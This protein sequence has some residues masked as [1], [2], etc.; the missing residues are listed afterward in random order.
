MI[1]ALHLIWIIPLSLIIGATI[2]AFIM[3]LMNMF[4]VLDEG[5]EKDGNH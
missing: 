2:G 1:N 5:G 4:K 3:A